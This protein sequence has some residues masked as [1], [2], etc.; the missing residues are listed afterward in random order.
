M[1]FGYDSTFDLVELG[2]LTEAGVSAAQHCT[3]TSL[4]F[5]VS[6]ADVGSSLFTELEARGG[7]T[8]ASGTTYALRVK[9]LEVGV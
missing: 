9:T 6:V 4:A 1:P 3:G 5:Q 2:S 7:Y 8:P